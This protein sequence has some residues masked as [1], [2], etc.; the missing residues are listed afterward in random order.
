MP[1]HEPGAQGSASYQS[2]DAAFFL[3]NYRLGKTLGVGSFGKVLPPAIVARGTPPRPRPSP[4]PT[5]ALAPPP[6]I[7]CPSMAAPASCIYIAWQ[8]GDGT[9]LAA[10]Q[11][12]GACLDGPQGGD[13][14]P[15]PP[16]D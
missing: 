3:S 4:A 11:G 12:G 7:T 6:I 9:A 16:Q 5:A 2:Q 14:D 10:G 13:Q 8:R 1:S 15:E